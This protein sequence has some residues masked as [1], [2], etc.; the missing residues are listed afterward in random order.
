MN[1]TTTGQG[2]ANICCFI[3]R[4]YV[5]DDDLDV[6]AGALRTLDCPAQ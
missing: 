6:T 4:S 2:R 3:F 5:D 1:K